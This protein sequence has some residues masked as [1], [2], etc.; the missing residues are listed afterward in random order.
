M[1]I[2]DRIHLNAIEYG[3]NERIFRQT[4]ECES[5]L[6]PMAIGD[7]GTSVGIAQIH[8]PAH[9]DVSKEEALDPE[10]AIRWAAKHFA[11]GHAYWWTCWKQR[12]PN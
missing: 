12:D 2:D 9:P 6:D 5:N 10:F 3:L 11:Q 1:T 7:S 4:L 8:L